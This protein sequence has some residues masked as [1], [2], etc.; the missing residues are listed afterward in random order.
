MSDANCA[1]RIWAFAAIA[2]PKT[3][4]AAN[5]FLELRCLAFEAAIDMPT[6]S[7]S[8]RRALAAHRKTDEIVPKRPHRR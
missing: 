6:S 5:C 7:S 2:K 4:A 3:I 8:E 1:R